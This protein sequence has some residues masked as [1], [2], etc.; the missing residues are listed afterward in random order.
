VY[1]IGAE[2]PD[3]GAWWRGGPCFA[4]ALAEPPAPPRPSV[5]TD[6]DWLWAPRPLRVEEDRNDADADRPSMDELGLSDS[7][8]DY[9]DFS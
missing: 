3:L 5:F 7:Q 6:A 2:C 4:L 8:R 9:Y 1:P